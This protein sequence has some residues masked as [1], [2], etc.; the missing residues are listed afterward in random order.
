MTMKSER[1]K[2]VAR[3]MPQQ[4]V[5]SKSCTALT[6]TLGTGV[7]C[8]DGKTPWA[9]RTLHVTRTVEYDGEPREFVSPMQYSM[10][11]LME[12]LVMP[13][14]TEISVIDEMNRQFDLKIER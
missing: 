13:G 2:S 7:L 4:K 12:A 10:G 9:A 6:L 3:Q 14:V 1:K 11:A 8:K 5:W